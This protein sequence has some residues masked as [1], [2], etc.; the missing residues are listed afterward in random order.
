MR[1]VDGAVFYGK[2]LLS[3]VVSLQVCPPTSPDNPKTEEF[4]F[5]SQPG[6][7]PGAIPSEFH[8]GMLKMFL[9]F[10]DANGNR[11][12]RTENG[13]LRYLY[14]LDKRAA[15]AI[16]DE[17]RSTIEAKPSVGGPP[18]E[19]YTAVTVARQDFKYTLEQ[20]GASRY[21]SKPGQQDVGQSLR[22]LSDRP[23]DPTLKVHLSGLAEAWTELH[24]LTPYEPPRVVVLSDEPTDLN[25][26][27]ID[28]ERRR[29]AQ[30]VVA[31]AGTEL[32]ETTLVCLNEL[33]SPT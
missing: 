32:C 8:Y 17:N 28:I 11:W 26:R 2:T 20:G 25:P 29:A 21:F 18:P 30:G 1:G 14:N 33:E 15:A 24:D 12:E 16:G 13:R 4:W 9:F 31:T 27:Q 22:D 23:L 3:T 7:D 19:I 6:L 10:T 5:R